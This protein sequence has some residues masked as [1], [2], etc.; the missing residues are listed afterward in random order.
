MKK[1]D[2]VLKENFNELMN[3]VSEDLLI[4]DGEGRVM[5]V[6]SSFESFYG[7]GDAG[8]L[9]GKTV[10]ELEGEGL[11]KPSVVAIVLKK[12]E[13]VTIIQ[14]NRLNRDIIV[15]ATPVFDKKGSIKFVVSYSRD[16]TEMTELQKKYSDLQK[17]LKRQS[18][19]LDRL[20]RETKVD[21]NIVC[22][23]AEMERVMDMVGK[24]SGFDV[25]VLLLGDSGV[26]KT[27]IAKVI[28]EKS[29]RANGPFVDINCAA[30]PENLLESELFGYEKGAFT[31]A[32]INGKIGLM[33]LAGGGTLLLDEIS[34][35]PIT[36]QAKLLKA[37][38]EKCITKI[39]GRRSI[40][41]DFRLIAASNRP[42]AEYIKEG[43]FRKDL[44]YRLNVV[45]ITIPP[46]AERKGDIIPLVEHFTQ[47]FN[48]KYSL[49]KSF[50]PKAM[51]AFLDCSWPGNVRELSNAVERAV[52]TGVN[53]IIEA[54]ELPDEVIESVGAYRADNVAGIDDLNKAL[55]EYEKEI[56]NAAYKKYGTTTKVAKH[57]NISQPTAHRKIDKY[58]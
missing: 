40:K 1:F 55:E 23:S 37:I 12:K 8:E 30:I 38:Q 57:L 29:D 18:A 3:S 39:G 53:D 31:G 14:K 20:R 41:V 49:D 35:M 52:V 54:E 44:F 24:V 43:K 36:L 11:F 34:E 50:S 51:E 21:S 7:V 32:S 26:G 6:D 22:R 2:E 33:E 56:I 13:K 47:L 27:M 45:N 15:T 5:R 17:E 58:R 4:S 28:H 25:N 16:I 10:Y 42:L 9:L 48:T 46:L 19:E